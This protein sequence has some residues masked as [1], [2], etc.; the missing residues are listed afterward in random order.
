MASLEAERRAYIMNEDRGSTER[1]S[2]S[3]HAPRTAS[4]PAPSALRKR[5]TSRGRVRFEDDAEKPD[6]DR[7]SSDTVESSSA[8]N[9]GGSLA[10]A[11]A[12]GGGAGLAAGI[13]GGGAVGLALAPFTL[14]LS[15]P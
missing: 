9:Q 13:V 7:K 10:V 12:K 2:R 6:G 14:G 15:I 8:G 1:R 4:T 3:E 11:A 5:R